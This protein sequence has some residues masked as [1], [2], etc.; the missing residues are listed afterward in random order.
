M[1]IS[2]QILLLRHA[3]SSWAD[4]GAHDYDRPLNERGLRAAGAM[5]RQFTRL[6]LEPQLILCSGAKRTRETYRR[7]GEAVAG[8]DVEFSDQIYEA[9]ETRLLDILRHVDDSVRRVMMIGHNPGL[10]YLS[11]TL[12]TG[13][14]NA[15]ALARL[16]HKYP[17]GALAIISTQLDRWTLLG[18]GACQ[19]DA[20]MRPV[21]DD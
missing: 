1:S 5:G 21:D 17:T 6:G 9:P 7:L 14:G 11:R 15:K 19:L 16:D 12:T 18:Q 13:Q 8:V 2:R 10:E 3:K 20:F 4:P